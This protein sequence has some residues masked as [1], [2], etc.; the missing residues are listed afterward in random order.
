MSR[1]PSSDANRKSVV[2]PGDVTKTPAQ[3]ALPT[4][5]GMFSGAHGA[6]NRLK[7]DISVLSLKKLKEEYL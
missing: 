3:Q 7:L 5:N 4:D 1:P 6:E 2:P